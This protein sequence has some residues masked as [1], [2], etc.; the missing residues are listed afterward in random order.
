VRLELGVGERVVGRADHRDGGGPGL[1]RVLCERDRLGRR[2]RPHVDGHVHVRGRRFEPRLGERPALGRAEE[3][4]LPGRPRDEYA[5]AAAPRDEGGEAADGVL[6]QARPTV[7][8]RRDDR[9][10]RSVQRHA[11]TVSVHLCGQ[12]RRRL[13]APACAMAPAS[14]GLLGDGGWKWTRAP[15]RAWNLAS[16]FTSFRI[17]AVA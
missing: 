12:S 10:D 11:P 1:G 4:P 13:P 2:L 3:D 5:V 16:V 9:R 6:V 17:E 15:P 8:Q 14:I 7:A